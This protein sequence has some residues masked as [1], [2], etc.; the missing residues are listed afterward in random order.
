[1]YGALKF[2]RFFCAKSKKNRENHFP[3]YE[4]YGI[5][6]ISIIESVATGLKILRKGAGIARRF[7][8][9]IYVN[10]DDRPRR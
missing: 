1:M 8:Y 5:I 10:K 7:P 3:F 6:Y 9:D 2:Y 4:E